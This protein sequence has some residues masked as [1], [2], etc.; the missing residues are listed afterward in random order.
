MANNFMS[1]NKLTGGTAG[2]LDDIDHNNLADGDV[3]AVI[4]A[5][6]DKV[7]FYRY[8]AS[9]AAAESSPDTINP[10]SHAAENGRWIL[11]AIQ[12]CS[13]YLRDIMQQTAISG[14][15]D[16]V[17]VQYD[18]LWI[19]AGAWTPTSTNGAAALSQNEHATADTI[20]NYLAFDGGTEEYADIDIVMPPTWD[21]STI[22]AKFYW[23]PATGCTAADTV[24]WQLQ[25]ISMTDD[26]DIDAQAYTDAGEVITDT[27]LAGVEE[28]LHVTAKTP[29]ITINGTPGLNHLVHLKM[30]RNVGGTDDMAEDAWLIGVLIEYKRTNSVAVW[31]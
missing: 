9:S 16:K 7:Y 14:F 21:R 28:D 1:A 22:S 23:Y 3:S 13:S 18:T 17:G 4:D 5:S 24:E 8:N 10:D 27:V 6:N 2:C 20:I 15:L 29:A 12:S 11:A 25:G 26:D 30:S 19:P 31:S